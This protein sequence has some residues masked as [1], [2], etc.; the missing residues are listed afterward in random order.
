VVVLAF[1]VGPTWEIPALRFATAGMTVW[2]G[3]VAGMT[4]GLVNIEAMRF[5]FRLL[6]Q[7][8]L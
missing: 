4:E 5:W 3:A 8:R 7:D 1:G 2:G 6:L